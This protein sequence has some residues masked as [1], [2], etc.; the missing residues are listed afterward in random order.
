MNNIRIVLVRPKYP[1][2]IGMVSRIM[3]NFGLEQL[4]L[5][6]PQNEIDEEARQGAAQG[7]GPLSHSKIYTDLASF[8]QNEPDGIRVAFS[9]RQGK[10]RACQ[11]LNQLVHDPIF[12]ERRPI[13]LFFGAEDHG[14]SAEELEQI[15]RMAFFELPGELQSMNLSHAVLYAISQFHGAEVGRN[16]GSTASG[17]FA[18]DPE[19]FLRLWLESL[20]FDL[21]SQNRWNALTM[22]K[23]LIM[24]AAPTDD[25]IH[26]L[27]M[28]VQHTIRKLKKN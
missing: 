28:I 15:H 26:K 10:R 16:E 27:E 20:N 3:A 22:L 6:A 4:F 12:K 19:P 7:Q 25:E 8:F 9:R 14:L 5:V 21:D 2:N 1:R 24:K 17:Q 13:Y 23:Q 11:A 18:K